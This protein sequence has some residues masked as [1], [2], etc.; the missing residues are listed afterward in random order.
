MY[1]LKQLRIGELVMAE[2]GVDMKSIAGCGVLFALLKVM[3]SDLE[4]TR[5]N[6][7]RFFKTSDGD[8]LTLG[9]HVNILMHKACYL[10]DLL[11]LLR[12]QIAISTVVVGRKGMSRPDYGGY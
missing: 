9:R 12:C 7:C 4:V 10:N 8:A 11:N 3:Y 1:F 6:F 2:R 5:D